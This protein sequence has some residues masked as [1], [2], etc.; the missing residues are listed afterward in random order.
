MAT[1]RKALSEI[2]GRIKH[3]ALNEEAERAGESKS[4][5]CENPKSTRLKKRCNL[6][7]TFNRYRP[8]GKAKYRAARKAARTRR[9]RGYRR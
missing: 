7:R 1:K 9:R 6:W 5:L 3:G 8:R 2:S 4:E